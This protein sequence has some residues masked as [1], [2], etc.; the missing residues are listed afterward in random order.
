MFDFHFQL[1]AENIPVHTGRLTHCCFVSLRSQ[2]FG[3]S[4]LTFAT[5]ARARIFVEEV[6]TVRFRGKFCVV[7]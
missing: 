6:C 2:A 1:K 5:R 3:L 4:T 7:E